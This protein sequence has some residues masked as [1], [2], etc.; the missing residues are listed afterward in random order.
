MILYCYYKDSNV[1]DFY[2]HDIIRLVML[3]IIKL[4]ILD[5][6]YKASNIVNFYAQCLLNANVAILN[7]SEKLVLI[8][9][10]SDFFNW[11]ITTDTLKYKEKSNYSPHP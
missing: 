3:I 4:I 9:T 11:P 5:F 7:K 6:Y 10:F 1:G 8:C 2:W